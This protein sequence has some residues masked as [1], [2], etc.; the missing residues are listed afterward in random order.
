MAEP[1]VATMMT[2]TVFTAVPDTPFL[3]LVATMTDRGINLMPVIDSTGRPIGVVSDADALAKLEYHCG[4]DYIPVLAGRRTRTRWHQAIARTAERLMTTPAPTVPADTPISIAAHL[5]ADSGPR[6]L[7][8]VDDTGRLVGV[9]TRRDLLRLYLRGDHAIKADIHAQLAATFH[10][11]QHITVQVTHGVATLSGTPTLHSTAEHA[12][13]IAR[14][15]PGVITTRN[16]LTYH[17][18]D[19]AYTGL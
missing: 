17:V 8:V 7:C 19:L 18:D 1:T 13:R 2:R 11:H 3:E 9:L 12:H 6:G 4:A 14:S 10:D 5:L 16:Q 15:I